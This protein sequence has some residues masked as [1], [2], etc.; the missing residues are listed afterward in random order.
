MRDKCE[1]EKR[2]TREKRKGKRKGKEKTRVR[3]KEKR[4]KKVRTR[5]AVEP[6]RQGRHRRRAR[7]Q[8]SVR[9]HH[10]ACLASERF[11]DDTHTQPPHA[12]QEETKKT[13][14]QKEMKKERKRASIALHCTGKN[15]TQH[16]THD[17][18]RAT[19]AHWEG[20]SEHTQRA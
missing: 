7:A 2:K 16:K 20:A 18:A 13:N 17:R 6:H 1:R 11:T 15:R 5:R 12:K 10:H 14:E 19:R 8:R 4:Q 9:Q 3:E